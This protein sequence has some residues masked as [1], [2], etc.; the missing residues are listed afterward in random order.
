MLRLGESEPLAAALLLVVHQGD[1]A[2]LNRLLEE[3][4][5]LAGVTIVRPGTGE[6]REFSYPAL[7]AATGWPGHFPNVGESIRLLIAAGAD[8][9]SHCS[10]LHEETPLHWAASSDGLEALDALL[11]AG[12][13][14]DAQGGVIAGGTPLA[15]AV[16]FG[17]WKAARRLIERGGKTELW[18]AVTL[19]LLG[20]LR[21]TS[22]SMHPLARR[23]QRRSGVLATAGGRRPLSIFLHAEPTSTGSAMTI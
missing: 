9:H 21:S 23:S 15:D 10:G 6:N 7:C 5:E 22:P 3:H 16:A 1:L 8:V 17:Q 13:D 12:A 4:S 20:Y 19:G 11:D 18:Q 14:I 2:S